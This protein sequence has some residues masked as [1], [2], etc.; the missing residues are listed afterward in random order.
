MKQIICD[1][2]FILFFWLTRQV[3][4]TTLLDVLPRGRE[5]LCNCVAL[6]HYFVS[7]HGLYITFLLIEQEGQHSI[8]LAGE[9]LHFLKAKYSC[10]LRWIKLEKHYIQMKNA[11]LNS[12]ALSLK[13]GVDSVR[14]FSDLLLW[15]NNLLLHLT[16]Y[17]KYTFRTV[18]TLNMLSCLFYFFKHC[19]SRDLSSS[20]SITAKHQQWH[21]H[22]CTI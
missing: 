12:T 18:K 1:E 21:L 14:E 3:C 9:E 5:F 15:N 16:K 19:A 22:Y 8:Y 6:M 2:M 10:N 20:K 13:Q 7:L 17:I 4:I 11:L